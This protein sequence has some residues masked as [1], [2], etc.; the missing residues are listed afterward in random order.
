MLLRQVLALVLVRVSS[1][2]QSMRSAF[3]DC[4]RAGWTS[5]PTLLSSSSLASFPLTAVEIYFYHYS[6]RMGQSC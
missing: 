4:Y 6:H 2:S 3:V 5:V 1:H